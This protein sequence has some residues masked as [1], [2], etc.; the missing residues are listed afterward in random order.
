MDYQ[1]LMKQTDIAEGIGYALAAS[2]VG[3]VIY[4]LT[5]KD[6]GG[7]SVGIGNVFSGMGVAI[8]GRM[9]RGEVRDTQHVLPSSL[10][11]RIDSIDDNR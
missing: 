1:R 10:E 8:M 9:V 3:L 11:T 2:G 6:T 4:G 5:E 7:I